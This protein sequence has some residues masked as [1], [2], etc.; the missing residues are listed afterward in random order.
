MGRLAARDKRLSPSCCLSVGPQQT[1]KPPGL[2]GISAGQMEF[3][4]R[5]EPALGMS[6]VPCPWPGGAWLLGLLKWPDLVLRG[7]TVSA[8]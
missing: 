8:G 2:G 5:P 1:V 7:E 4:E 6:P 3:A